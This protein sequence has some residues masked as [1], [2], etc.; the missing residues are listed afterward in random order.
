MGLVINQTYA[1]IGIETTPGRLAIQTQ[2]AKLELHQKHAK[3]NIHT[4]LPKVEI[5]QYEC[6][7]SAGLKGIR[8]LTKEITDRAY[9]QVME[10]IGKIAEDGDRLAAIEKGGNPIADIAERDAYPEHEFG[11]AT[12]PTASPKFTVKG[13]V[14]FDPEPNGQGITNGVEGK[15][16]PGDVSISYTPAQ[17]RTYMKQYASISIRYQPDH[18]IDT[19]V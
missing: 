1:Q 7:A 5:D 8:D 14:K 16:S 9:Q 13:G 3:V 15:Y 2:D 19:H 4:E 12:I 17:V 6:F 10:Y 11:Y 18:K